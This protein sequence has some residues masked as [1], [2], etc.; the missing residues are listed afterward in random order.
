MNN[1]FFAKITKT[2]TGKQKFNV[3][4]NVALHFCL[5]SSERPENSMCKSMHV[6]C[7][8]VSDTINNANNISFVVIPPSDAL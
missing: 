5:W 4:Y 2:L 8:Q 7:I 6:G 1:K 3:N